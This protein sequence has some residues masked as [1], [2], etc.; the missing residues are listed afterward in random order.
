MLL[1]S[2]RRDNTD[3]PACEE[4]SVVAM[5]TLDQNANIVEELVFAMALNSARNSFDGRTS[6]QT[7]C[8]TVSV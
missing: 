6:A 3:L 4:K 7:L 1:P 2:E 5:N 8:C